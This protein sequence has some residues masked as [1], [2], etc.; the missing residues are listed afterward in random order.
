MAITGFAAGLYSHRK[1]V[2]DTLEASDPGRTGEGR[3]G[4]EF[5]MQY[6]S[7]P[8]ALRVAGISAIAICSVA[9]LTARL[10]HSA[11]NSVEDQKKRLWAEQ[12]RGFIRAG[13]GKEVMLA[14]RGACP[15]EVWESVD[16]V[17]NFIRER[18]GLM[19]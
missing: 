6:K 17:T 13:L 14:G 19:L 1:T 12:V 16:S 5:R 8:R 4:K 18:S 2:G 9:F 3:P 15:E 7:L 11:T 10:S